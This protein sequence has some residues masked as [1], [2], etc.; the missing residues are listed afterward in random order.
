MECECDECLECE[1]IKKESLCMRLSFLIFFHF[2]KKFCFLVFID[3]NREKYPLSSRVMNS[4]STWTALDKTKEN[5]AIFRLEWFIERQNEIQKRNE[6]WIT[7]WGNH[8]ALLKKVL[9][10]AHI[11]KEYFKEEIDPIVYLHRLY[12]EENLSIESVLL[13]IRGIYSELWE[14][15]HFY[16]TPNSLQV[17]LRD[18]LS[19]KL[20]NSSENKTTQL[21]KKRNSENVI[22]SILE[23]QN[24]RKVLFLWWYIKSSH[25]KSHDLKKNIFESFS[26]K[27]EKFMYVLENVL[28]IKKEDFL[29]LQEIDLWEK[30]I[31]DR[32]NE[33]FDELKIDLQVSHKDI[34]RIFEKFST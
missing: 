8:K 24:Q 29:M 18:I 28:C 32:F 6:A 30:F 13:K 7:K 21:Y 5:P 11:L 17:F 2:I 4:I 15:K 25:L 12:F 16:N 10:F 1:C 19:W 3:L 22:Q 23:R 9:K 20:K 34:K 33:I 26:F 14:A 27:Y 31:S